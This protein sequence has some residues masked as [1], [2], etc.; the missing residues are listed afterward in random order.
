MWLDRLGNTVSPVPPG[1]SFPHAQR[2]SSSQNE[3]SIPPAR[4][5][6]SPRSS[7][8]GI[9]SDTNAST[10]LSPGLVHQGQTNS[11]MAKQPP[12]TNSV[13]VRDP[14]EVLQAVLGKR[15]GY[16]NGHEK[17][18]PKKAAGVSRPKEL[19]DE[20]YFGDLSLEEF[21]EK[22]WEEER[23]ESLETLTIEQ[24]GCIFT[25]RLEL[26]LMITCAQFKQIKTGLKISMKQLL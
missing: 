24:C 2:V 21:V 7:S 13:V 11:T 15:E 9:S 12:R 8:L 3:S 16:F 5:L 23:Q 14:L 25:Y 10:V 20:I 26:C 18:E 4:P 17:T 22:K 1:R 19:V 6:F